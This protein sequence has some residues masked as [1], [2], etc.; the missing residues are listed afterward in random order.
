MLIDGPGAV[1]M[2]DRDNCVFHVSHVDFPRRKD[3]LAHVTNTLLDGELVIDLDKATRKK[4]PRYLI[5]DI[6]TFE[7]NVLHPFY[8]LRYYV[9]KCI[10]VSNDF[11]YLLFSWLNGISGYFCALQGKEVGKTDFNTRLICI[12]KEIYEPR[13]SKQ[14]QGLLDRSKEPFGIRPKPFYDLSQESRINDVKKVS[15]F[16]N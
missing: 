9:T 3:L 6:I 2:I 14:Q 1:Y 7:V 11:F 4:T 10:L 5:Y 15:R 8:L 12:K 13:V 16:S